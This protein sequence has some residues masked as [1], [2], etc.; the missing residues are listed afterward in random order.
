MPWFRDLTVPTIPQEGTSALAIALEAEQDE[1]AALLHAHLS[2]GQPQSLVSAAPRLQE[3]RPPPP[4]AGFTEHSKGAPGRR[5]PFRLSWGSTQGQGN[6]GLTPC[7]WLGP[8]GPPA[9]H[10]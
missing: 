10:L 9:K 1:V 4:H 6:L 8:E 7:M 5:P 3:P 2:S